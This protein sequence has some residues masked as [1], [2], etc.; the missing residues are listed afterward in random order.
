MLLHFLFVTSVLVNN[1]IV[2]LFSHPYRLPPET[3]F[4][5]DGLQSQHM[6]GVP[7]SSERLFMINFSFHHKA[8]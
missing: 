2:H 3:L 5:K 6:D 4:A 7:S 1:E 8:I